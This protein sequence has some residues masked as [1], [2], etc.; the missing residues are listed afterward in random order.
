MN[1]SSHQADNTLTLKITGRWDYK[2]AKAFQAAYKG[3]T[4]NQTVIL[5]LRETEMIDSA[6]LGMLLM[7]RETLGHEQPVTIFANTNI[8]KALGIALFD[9]IFNIK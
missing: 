9:K 6:A 7:L 2:G 3:C 5:D 8:K 4:L 1:I